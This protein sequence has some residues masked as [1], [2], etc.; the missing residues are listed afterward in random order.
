VSAVAFSEGGLVADQLVA[1]QL[2]PINRLSHLS[3]VS[4]EFRKRILPM[5]SASSG[6]VIGGADGHG[7]EVLASVDRTGCEVL[8]RVWRHAGADDP[9]LKEVPSGGREPPRSCT[10]GG[11]GLRVMAELQSRR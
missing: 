5:V 11:S 3:I 8:S 6:A 1:E 10:G 2:A 7:E 4:R 9:R